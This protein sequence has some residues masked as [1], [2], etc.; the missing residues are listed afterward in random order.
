MK[1][2]SLLVYIGF[3]FILMG[4]YVLYVQA[5]MA[6]FAFT[7]G[8]AAYLYA[9]SNRLHIDESLDTHEVRLKEETQ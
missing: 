6:F 4:S 5:D 3:V 2:S 8:S 9:H 7:V 1:L